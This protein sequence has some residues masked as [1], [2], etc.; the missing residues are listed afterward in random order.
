LFCSRTLFTL[1][2]G[3]HAKFRD[4]C[5]SDTDRAEKVKVKLIL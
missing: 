1:G 4:A 2:P 5:I 3:M